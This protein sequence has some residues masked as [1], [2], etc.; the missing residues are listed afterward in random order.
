MRRDSA[1]GSVIRARV[2]AQSFDLSKVDVIVPN[3]GT[4]ETLYRRIDRVFPYLFPE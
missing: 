1:P 3:D 2:A 4:L